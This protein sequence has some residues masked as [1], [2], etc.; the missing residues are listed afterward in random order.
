MEDGASIPVPR[1]Y[2]RQILF[3]GIGAAGQAMIHE[4]TVAIVG[5]GAL[6][7][8]Q[9]SLL[10][11]AGVGTVRLIDRDFVEESNLQRQI[12][13]DESDV[14]GM[15]PKA[16]AAA[17]K[18]RAANSL[19][20]VEDRVEEVNAGTIDRLLEGCGVILDASDNFDVRFLIN[21]YCVKHSIPWIYGACVGAQGNVL[22]VLPGE[23]VCLRCVF[24]GPP[25]AGL[26]PTCDTAGV[27]GPIAGVV[28]SLQVAEAMKVLTGHRAQVN[29]RMM[30]LDLWGNRFDPVAL[31]PRSPDCPCCGKHEYPYLDGIL[32]ADALS[33]CGRNSVQIRRTGGGG[34]DLEALAARL[35]PVAKVERNRFLLR[36]FVDGYSLTVFADG[37]AI[38]GGTSDLG[39][40]KSIYAR[41]VGN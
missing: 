33:L 25:P 3:A 18:L 21:D 8:F 32:G 35:G 20:K 39:V 22:A 17:G 40:A 16:V 41:Y 5:C 10:V 12:L 34:V 11:R 6:G 28:A 31:P 7:T 14:G 24:D 38:V 23:T 19:V 26:S 27:I 1:R 29:R 4:S 30:R 9:A 37:R 13:F 36:A 15:L 2:S